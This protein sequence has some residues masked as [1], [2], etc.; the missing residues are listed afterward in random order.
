MSKQIIFIKRGFLCLVLGCLFLYGGKLTGQSP[1][2]LT[3]KKEVYWISAGV[4]A[5]SLG[6][7]LSTT[8]EPFTADQILALDAKNI[9]SFDRF[10]TENYSL[11][12]QKVSDGFLASSFAAGIPFLLKKQVRKDIF[13]LGVIYAEAATITAGVTL[14][15]KS[16]TERPRPFVYN[17][18]VDF[19][20]KIRRQARHSFFSGHTSIAAMNTF[21][22]AKIFNDYYPDSKYKAYIWTGAALI[23]AATAYSRVEGGKHFPT[24]A[25]AGY[26]VGALIGYFIPH[27]HKVR[28][29]KDLG[30][31]IEPIPFGVSLK[32]ELK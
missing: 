31:H 24:D 1:Y 15:S 16:L 12:I 13:T 27:F 21:F 2:K 3:T 17:S 8:T 22:L 4:S 30:L 32:V 23:P 7:A 25:M 29:Q 14:L 26:A 28:N 10:A 6:Y 19:E 18:Q 11:K 20:E 9:N 5:L